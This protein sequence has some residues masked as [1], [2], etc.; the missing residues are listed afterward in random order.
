MLTGAAT[1]LFLL[2][3]GTALLSRTYCDAIS[4]VHIVT[5]CV[6]TLL[7]ALACRLRPSALAGRLAALAV[8]GAASAA[9]YIFW[10][11]QCLSGPFN[12]LDPLSYRLWY[13]NVKEGRPVWELGGSEALLWLGYPLLGLAGAVVAWRNTRE[14]PLRAFLLDYCALLT[15]ATAIG[16]LVMRA[17]AFSNLLAIP[18]GVM[19]ILFAFARTE[20]W[21]LALRAPLRAMAA[22]LLCPFGVMLI[23]S[24]SA[25]PSKKDEAVAISCNRYLTADNLAALDALPRTTLLAPLDQ[26]PALVASTHHWAIGASYH[27]NAGAIHDV[28]AFFTAE[29]QEARSIASRHEAHYVALCPSGRDVALMAKLYPKGLAARLKEGRP[30]D[31]LRPIELTGS[32]GMRLYAVQ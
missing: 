18:G 16:A 29:D 27:R 7:T 20:S 19:F 11:P 12:M 15:I 2:V 17:G 25:G 5:F 21:R 9:V 22:L 26:S 28:L 8:A 30:P 31:W 10:A 32:D 24:L 1:L 23:I 4:P 13:L 6:A 14:Q 3:H